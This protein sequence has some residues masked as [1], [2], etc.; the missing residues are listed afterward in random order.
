V[1]WED[2]AGTPGV[3]CA[4]DTVIIPPE[5]SVAIHT[6]NSRTTIRGIQVASEAY[7]SCADLPSYFFRM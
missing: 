5:S 4:A 1:Q 3:P 2:S 6:R 7:D